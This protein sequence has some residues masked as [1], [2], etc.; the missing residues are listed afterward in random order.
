M[1]KNVFLFAIVVAMGCCDKRE[2]AADP[3]SSTHLKEGQSRMIQLSFVPMYGRT[4][5][6]EIDG[7]RY[8]GIK[9]VREVD[10][11][12]GKIKMHHALLINVICTDDP[13]AARKAH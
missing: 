5:S 8:D 6:M 3:D 11:I 12:L 10:D 9:S 7:V 4:Y 1:K 13:D 2:R